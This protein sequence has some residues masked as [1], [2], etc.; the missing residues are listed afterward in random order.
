MGVGVGVEGGGVGLTVDVGVGRGVGDPVGVAVA[1]SVL[2]GVGLGV[3]SPPL[4][5]SHAVSSGRKTAARRTASAQDTAVSHW[6]LPNSTAQVSR[7][8]VVGFF[9][10]FLSQR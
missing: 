5:R 1:V 7:L 10:T 8:R 4:T 2:V 3:G 6:A 9:R